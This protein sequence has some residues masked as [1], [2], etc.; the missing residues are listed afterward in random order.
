MD[1]KIKESG[2][3]Q[4]K[5]MAMGDAPEGSGEKFGV[6]SFDSM[7]GNVMHPDTGT[8]THNRT[9]HDHERGA[10]H[11]IMHDGS[12]MHAQANANHGPHDH[13]PGMVRPKA[14]GY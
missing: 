1:K 6:E 5:A 8:G 2:I 4:H 13:T 10:R 14:R 9:L 11:P 3:R 7:N 12:K